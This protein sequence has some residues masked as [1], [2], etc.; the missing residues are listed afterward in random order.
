MKPQ[1]RI[2]KWS[3]HNTGLKK[4]DSLTLWVEESALAGWLVPNQNNQPG[5]SLY[6]SDLAIA[7]M[8]TLK[9]V[10]HLLGRQCQGLLESIFQLMYPELAVPGH[11][12]LSRRDTTGGQ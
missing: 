5:A 6:Y 12:T 11:S 10:Y 2:Y 9:A 8:A 1:Y 4:R 7:T 3:K